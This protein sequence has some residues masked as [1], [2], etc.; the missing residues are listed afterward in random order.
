[1]LFFLL[2]WISSSNI[3]NTCLHHL[4]RTVR[5]HRVLRAIHGWS[6]TLKSWSQTVNTN[7][8]IDKSWKDEEN[9]CVIE[10]CCLERVSKESRCEWKQQLSPVCFS[11]L[12]HVLRWI[13]L[14]I[15][16]TVWH[17]AF[18]LSLSVLAATCS[19]IT[20]GKCCFT[21]SYILVTKSLSVNFLIIRA[22]LF[23][24]CL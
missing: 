10:I 14:D 4:S 12:F 16:H 5:L 3:L 1:M 21:A 11:F 6:F 18:F 20:S 22:H 7:K 15:K 9:K 2:Y 19:L 17:W 23:F 8:F 24:F 13:Q